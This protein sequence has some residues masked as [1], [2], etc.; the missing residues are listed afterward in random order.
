MHD[1]GKRSARVV[2]ALAAASKAQHATLR[3]QSD[4]PIDPDLTAAYMAGSL[5]AAGAHWVMTGMEKSALEMAYWFSSMAAP[6][7]LD[8]IGLSE[9]GSQE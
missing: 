5:M 8:L 1:D 3:A 6:G 4:N 2:N 9:I 7:L